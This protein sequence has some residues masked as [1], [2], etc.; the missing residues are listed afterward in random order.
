MNKQ[1]NKT[2]A[3]GDKHDHLSRYGF[4]MG[5]SGAHAS[6][7]MMLDELYVLMDAALPQHQQVGLHGLGHR[8]QSA[9]QGDGEDVCRI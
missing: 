3:L 9:G 2:A 4:R 1:K 8:F 7:T 6:R 5:R